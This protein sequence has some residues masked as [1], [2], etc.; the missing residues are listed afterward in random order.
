[1]KIN[2]AAALAL[3]GWYL[4]LPPIPTDRLLVNTDAPIS[5]WEQYQA[6]DSA[7]ECEA[8]NLYIHKEARKVRRDRRVHP[9]TLDDAMAEQYINGECI[10]ADDPRLKER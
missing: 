3:V 8:T 5:K 9:A 7:Q 6:F 1:M 4:M 2:H 10:E